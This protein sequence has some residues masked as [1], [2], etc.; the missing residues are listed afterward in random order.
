[1][2]C[3]GLEG[4]EGR[5]GMGSNWRNTDVAFYYYIKN[6]TRTAGRDLFHNPDLREGGF[7]IH[8]GR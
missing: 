5:C 6:E 3:L 1:M 8:A 4:G 2:S 7:L